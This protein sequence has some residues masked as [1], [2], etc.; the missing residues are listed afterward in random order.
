M[1]GVP[2]CM[3]FWG[4][5]TLMNSFSPA[6]FH[7]LRSSPVSCLTARPSTRTP[8][9]DLNRRRT[10][11]PATYLFAIA[12]HPRSARSHR[13]LLCWPAARSAA[14]QSMYP[15]HAHT[16]FRSLPAPCNAHS[17]LAMPPTL[18]LF[19]PSPT[20]ISTRPTHAALMPPLRALQSP[21]P[22]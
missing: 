10:A 7:Q 11:A 16:T 22:R 8:H 20:S 2:E 13:F 9:F 14:W 4:A 18:Q 1:Q 5:G 19:A 21:R 12:A 6:P 17:S 3:T 15:K